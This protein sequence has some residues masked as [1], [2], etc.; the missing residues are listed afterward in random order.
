MGRIFVGS[1]KKGGGGELF[2]EK[3]L[4]IDLAGNTKFNSIYL[5]HDD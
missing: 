1:S 3:M 4:A 2:I 5:L